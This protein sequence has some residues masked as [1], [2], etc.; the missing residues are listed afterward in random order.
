MTRSISLVLS[1]VLASPPATEAPEPPVEV[2]DPAAR[3]HFDAGLKAWLADDYAAAEREL[4]DAAGGGDPVEA[5]KRAVELAVSY[6]YSIA[7]ELRNVREPVE[8]FAAVRTGGASEGQLQV[9]PVCRMAVDPDRAAGRLMHEGT[10]YFFC[11][12]TCAGEF[13]RQPE[14]YG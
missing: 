8:L 12:L 6:M 7:A 2:T 10:A 13:A 1:V 14:R 4:C 9:D 5:A 3:V 11:T